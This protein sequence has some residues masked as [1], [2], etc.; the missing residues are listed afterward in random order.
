[1]HHHV[2]SLEEVLWGITLTAIT[3][4]MHG[5]GMVGTLFVAGIVK[6]ETAGP[7]S[8]LRGSAMLIVVSW[9]I[10][11]VYLLEVFVWAVFF[12]WQG[13]R[14]NESAS[15]YFSFLQYTTVQ[16]PQS[17]AALGIA[18]GHAAHRRTADIRLVDRRVARPRGGIPEHAAVALT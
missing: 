11:L 5:Y 16:R 8:F 12:V 2:T 15:Y 9:M 1:M 17:A 10:S 13:A 18:R 6:Y 3:M 14:P 4:A 7:I